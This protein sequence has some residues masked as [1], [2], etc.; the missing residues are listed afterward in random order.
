MRLKILCAKFVG[1]GLRVSVLTNLCLI[2]N[3]QLHFD[4]FEEIALDQVKSQG[5]AESQ[6]M[7]HFLNLWK[8]PSTAVSPLDR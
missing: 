2:D 3:H 5:F 8:P 7:R 1:A 4:L 6:S